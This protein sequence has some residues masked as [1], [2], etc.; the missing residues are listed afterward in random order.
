MQNI[1]HLIINYTARQHSKRQE[2]TA[3]NEEKNQSIK[4]DPETTRILELIDKDIEAVI[5]TVFH[6]FEK[7]EERLHM[8]NTSVKDI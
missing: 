7:V 3:L 8:L 5:T 4:T 6:V 1:W 2:N